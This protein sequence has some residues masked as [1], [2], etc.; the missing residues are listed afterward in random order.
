MTGLTVLRSIDDVIGDYGADILASDTMRLTQ[1]YRQHGHT[2]IFEH[3]VRVACMSLRIARR[4]G[5]RVNERAMVRGALL[6]D[7]FL[8]DWHVRSGR[9]KW[10]GFRHAG[11]ALR[12]AS[13]DFE[14]DGVEKDIIVKHMFPLNIMPP[15]YRESVIVCIADKLCA[16]GEMFV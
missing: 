3:S 11:A 13:R 7:Y 5:L 10:H 12:N 14:L 6:H 8:Y 15:V 9:P 2:S 16:I 1:R 4:L